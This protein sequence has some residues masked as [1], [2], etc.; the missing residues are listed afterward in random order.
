M[1]LAE[2]FRENDAA[3]DGDDGREFARIFC[4]DA[5]G[6]VAAHGK[7][8]E[9]SVLWIALEFLGSGSERGERH[10]FH[11]RRTPPV[12]LQALRKNDDGREAGAVEADSGGNADLRL[13]QAVGAAFAG[14][15]KKQN[16]GPRFFRGPVFREVH[17]VF[18]AGG[19]Q[20][21]GAVEE[22]GFRFAG[23]GGNGNERRKSQQN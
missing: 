3:A 5:P 12:V 6:A 23:G 11:F 4:G 21:E 20:R 22:T 7:S 9:V 1:L 18:V 17:L 2:V 15:V 19:V 8:G 10:F 16:D 13:E 14:A